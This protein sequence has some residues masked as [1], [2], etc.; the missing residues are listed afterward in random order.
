MSHSTEPIGNLAL[1]RWSKTFSPSIYFWGRWR[2]SGGIRGYGQRILNFLTLSK[3]PQVGPVRS[4]SFR[5]RWAANGPSFTR[6]PNGGFQ[7]RVAAS[8]TAGMAWEANTP[9]LM[10]RDFCSFISVAPHLM[11]GLAFLRIVRC[12]EEPQKV[13]QAPCQARGD[14]RLLGLAARST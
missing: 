11:R 13:S 6:L 2:P 7:V 3:C 5:C 14:E 9:A 12:R 10:D 4:G 8:A 1:T